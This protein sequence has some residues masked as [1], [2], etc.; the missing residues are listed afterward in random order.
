[1]KWYL[2]TLA[3]YASFWGFLGWGIQGTV[4]SVVVS[5]SIYLASLL[6]TIFHWKQ[7]LV[8]ESLCILWGPCMTIFAIILRFNE[9]TTWR[10]AA[11]VVASILQIALITAY[12]Y[13]KAKRTHN[14][15]RANTKLGV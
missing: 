3:M 10:I 1:M 13:Y 5:L 12:F 7:A 15:N 2:L 9:M 6:V 11:I 8:K 4:V 14:R